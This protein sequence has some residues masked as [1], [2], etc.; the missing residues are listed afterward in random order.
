MFHNHKLQLVLLL[1]NILQFDLQIL[2][3]LSEIGLLTVSHAAHYAMLTPL[4]PQ[5]LLTAPSAFVI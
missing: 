1:T 5:S 4:K 2:L 3:H